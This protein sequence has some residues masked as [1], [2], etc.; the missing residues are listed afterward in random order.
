MTVYPVPVFFLFRITS[1]QNPCGEV[2]L[3]PDV[4]KDPQ[5]IDLPSESF[6]EEIRALH[7]FLQER[8]L[9]LSNPGPP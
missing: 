7:L 1:P 5:L 4:P 2:I 6:P 9:C 3:F 8:F